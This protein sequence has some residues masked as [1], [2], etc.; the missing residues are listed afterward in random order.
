[1]KTSFIGI[2]AALTAW[3]LFLQAGC[4]K[5][6]TTAVRMT[7]R[8]VSSD[9]ERLRIHYQMNGTP[10]T[11]QTLD[12][13]KLKDGQFGFDLPDASTGILNVQIE[14]I[15]EYPFVLANCATSI[16]VIPNEQAQAE[17]RLQRVDIC[18]PE[19]WCWER[20]LPSGRPFLGIWGAS[21]TDV[22]AVS[23]LGA[24]FHFDGEVW[25]YTD[26]GIAKDLNSV[27][28]SR[29]DD[30]WAVGDQSTVLH[31]DG[32]SW[33][34]KT[35]PAPVD[36]SMDIKGVW[37]NDSKNVWFWGNARN[38]DGVRANS[39]GYAYALKWDGEKFQVFDKNTHRIARKIIP[40]RVWG[41]KNYVYLLGSYYDQGYEPMLLQYRAADGSV[42]ESW[43]ELSNRLPKEPFLGSCS[44]LTGT[45]VDD[46]WLSCFRN[47]YHWDNQEMKALPGIPQGT[48]THLW[49]DT[50]GDLWL[51]GD[52]E[53]PET[54]SALLHWDGSKAT[55]R[56]TEIPQN[57]FL[58][59]FWG[60]GAGSLWVGGKY[61]ILRQYRT[62]ADEW[63]HFLPKDLP[64][65]GNTVSAIT[66]T[67]PNDLW[68]VQEDGAIWRSDGRNWI[69]SYAGVQ[70]G[71]FAIWSG[72]KNDIWAVGD[73]Q[74]LHYDGTTWLP[75]DVRAK[76]VLRSVW[77][78]RSNSVWAGGGNQGTQIFHW[79]GN[80]WEPQSIPSPGNRFYISDIMGTDN[81]NVWATGI[82][83]NTS[84]NRQL[85]LK[86][87]RDHWDDQTSLLYS[88]GAIAPNQ[89]GLGHLWVG[90]SENIWLSDNST[91]T[92]VR[93]DG[94]TW[95][96]LKFVD[97]GF[98]HALSPSDFTFLSRSDVI[99]RSTQNNV[100]SVKL[101]AGL[102][103]LPGFDIMNAWSFP[104]G[105]MWV[106][107]RGG[108]VIH[109][110]LP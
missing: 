103:F 56:A 108:L 68:I 23:T 41:I 1:M 45:D 19:R 2:A 101:L 4:E 93:F 36:K 42:P 80:R 16:A 98:I 32:A 38:D 13:S 87:T 97:Y 25:T 51:A 7:M 69:P 12:V 24:I 70:K 44:G 96:G 85:F 8:E 49:T 66:G 20:P 46:I 11:D 10:Q 61:G 39:Y 15:P 18:T 110:R 21:P 100:Y 94:I 60:D 84:T 5:K 14:A 82:G 33:S 86:Y 31:Y 35:L 59:S 58:L 40:G 52:P 106:V 83:D 92:P 95:R 67:G 27:W 71:L 57:P 50:R 30:V 88:S 64:E 81:D 77:G 43:T 107:G 22:W 89:W 75:V 9:F 37:A 99:S 26:T 48:W 34:Q 73:N 62:S 91:S 53:R 47:T 29:S 54:N 3:V 109:K 79:D 90:D 63:R 74:A 78:A 102:G 17:C 6:A 104:S 28:G 105:E 72:S 55:E 76:T 65:I